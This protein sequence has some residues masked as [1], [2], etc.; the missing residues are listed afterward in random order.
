MSTSSTELIKAFVEAIWVCK[1][2]GIPFIRIDSLCI[3]H[4]QSDWEIQ[5]TRMG[6][7]FHYSTVTIA[8]PDA[9]NPPEGL[10]L[11]LS[12]RQDILAL[13]SAFGNNRGQ[14]YLMPSSYNW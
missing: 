8:A 14:A 1:E 4:S 10:R 6:S 5:S 2:L 9:F 3:A 7:I 13:H 12:T 11:P